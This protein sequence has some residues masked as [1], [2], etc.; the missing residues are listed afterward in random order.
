M[1]ISSAGSHRMSRI[2][3]YQDGNTRIA[4]TSAD[5]GSGTIGTGHVW[6]SPIS[7]MWENVR[8]WDQL[9][10][11]SANAADDDSGYGALTQSY[12]LALSIKTQSSS[13]EAQG[14]YEFWVHI[15]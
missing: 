1:L 8:K 6:G 13:S 5:A 14:Y 9:D 11:A 10:P 4:M 12:F 2:S 15:P 7:T 3:F